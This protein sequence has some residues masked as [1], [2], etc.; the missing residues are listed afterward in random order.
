MGMG[1]LQPS[2]APGGAAA[3]YWNPAL[4]N[5]TPNGLEF[6]FVV[7]HQDIS[8]GLLPR[9]A[10]ANIPNNI[11]QA[12]VPAPS[13]PPQS[14][15]PIP[16]PTQ[17]LEQGLPATPSQ[18]AIPPSPRQGRDTGQHTFTYEAIGLNYKLFKDYLALGVYALIPNGQFMQM[19]AFYN[20]ER[21]QYMS[22]S[23]HPELY[24]DRLTA[25]SIA[26]GAGV[27]IYKG[28]TLGVGAT[29]TMAA[30]VNSPAYVS[31]AADIDKLLLDLKGGVDMSVAPHFGL[32]QTLAHNRLRLTA[33][34]HAPSEV[35]FATQFTFQ[36]GPTSPPQSSSVSFLLDYS[37]WQANA[38]IAGDVI[39]NEK[40]TL[41][42]VGSVNY[43]R[44][45]QY[46]DRHNERPTSSYSWSDSLSPTVG[47]RFKQGGFSS[48]ADVA[49]TPTP[50]PEQTGRSNYVDN[51]RISS[52]LGA[53]Y[54]FTAWETKLELGLLFQLHRLLPR[55]NTKAETP[56]TGNANPE[57]VKD[58]LPD[59]AVTGFNAD[60]F[61]GAAG[62]Q[63]NNPGW[64]G[65]SSQGWITGGS[66]VLKIFL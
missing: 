7:L 62:L 60:P 12:G 52:A 9:P 20:D 48:M 16:I 59:N 66:V 6:S 56:T 41:T 61:P 17:Q 25:I 18:E 38:G 37:P 14:L 53:S 49:Y 65:F 45:S 46:M 51:D 44:W 4:L 32:S 24:G 33:T 5:D 40:R 35:K 28:L 58:E 19:Q 29:L 42:L 10:S 54:A 43:A 8:V 15:N 13:G 47:L 55:N 11:T 34:A 64:P 50:V 1:G 22:N 63:T 31:N 26:L 2:A 27:R 36:I 23:L 30:M 3:S 21:E 57:L 39:Q